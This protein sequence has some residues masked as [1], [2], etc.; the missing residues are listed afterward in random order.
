MTPAPDLDAAVR[1]IVGADELR[2]ADVNPEAIDYDAFLAGRHVARVSGTAAVGDTTVDWSFIEKRTEGP[3]VA[4]AYLY[5][6]AR[7]EVA[8][9]RSGLLADLAAEVK[10][11]RLLAA[12]QDGAGALTLWI[13]DLGATAR[14]VASRDEIVVAARHLGR[15]SGRWL[16]QVPEHEW[17]FGGWIDRHR[18][19]EAMSDALTLIDAASSKPA[20]VARLGRALDEIGELITAQDAYAPALR[21]LPITL[22]HHDAVAANVFL[23]PTAGGLE[24]VLI[25]WE[26]VGPGPIGADLA[27]LLFASPRRGDFSARLLADV[28]RDALDAYADG[29][30][31]A[32]ASV[33][34]DELRLG[35]YASI[36]LRWALARDVIG[37]LVGRS[38]ARRG[39]APHES[40]DQ[41]LDELLVLVPVLLDS[42]AEARRIIAAG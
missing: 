23:R 42:A 3:S 24:T 28:M 1:R 5:D 26:S 9:Y 40:A 11:P 27:S 30:A 29:V 34:P 15:M 37:I 36:A 22:C 6:N 39:S 13:E 25:D 18:Q 2:V 17:L 20:V 33:D 31:E 41:A 16:G 32:G 7:R 38:T 35:L 8:A 10:A 19:P 4:S 14:P 21:R 12:E